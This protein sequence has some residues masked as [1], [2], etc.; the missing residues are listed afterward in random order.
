MIKTAKIIEDNTAENEAGIN[1]KVTIYIPE[2]DAKV[3]YTIVSTMLSEIL[4]LLY[5]N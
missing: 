5:R 2:D 3:T 1:K 4:I